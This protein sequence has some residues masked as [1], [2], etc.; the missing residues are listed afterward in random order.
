MATTIPDCLNLGALPGAMDD[1][2]TR[3][4]RSPSG[5]AARAGIGEVQSPD[6]R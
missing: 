3:T 5:A 2:T 1:T 4:P 6:P